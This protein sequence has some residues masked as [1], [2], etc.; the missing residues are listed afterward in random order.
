MAGATL[1]L[2]TH[3]DARPTLP[4]AHL[5]GRITLTDGWLAELIGEFEQALRYDGEALVLCA[6]IVTCP[7]HSPPARRSSGKET[8]SRP[9]KFTLT[10]RRCWPALREL[11]G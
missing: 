7:W 11:L 9:V 1:D 10:R 3:A 6:G 8:A 2:V 4:T 5:E